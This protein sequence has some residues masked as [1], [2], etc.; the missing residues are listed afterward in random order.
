MKNYLA[1]FLFIII[2]FATGISIAFNIF[3]IFGREEIFFKNTKNALI[4]YG[5]SVMIAILFT[6]ISYSCVIKIQE[7][8]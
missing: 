3:S 5:I 2:T 7:Q 6:I 4:V 1:A 8:Y